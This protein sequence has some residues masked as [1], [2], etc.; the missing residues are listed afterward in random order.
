MYDIYNSH[1]GMTE[2]GR[3]EVMRER[4]RDLIPQGKNPISR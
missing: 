3:F 2:V 1:T 4:E